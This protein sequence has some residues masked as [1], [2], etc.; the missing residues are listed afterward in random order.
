MHPLISDLTDLKTPELENKISDLTR[1]Y[2]ASQNPDV[3][4]QVV[5]ILETYK[6]ELAKRQ[7]AEY[8][9]M[10]NS[11]NKDLDKLINVQ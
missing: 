8:N 7:L 3:R 4:Q 5:M 11:R 10:M 9:K 1:K 6:E 2:F